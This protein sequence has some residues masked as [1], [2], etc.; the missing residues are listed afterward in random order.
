MELE[1]L[2]V[3]VLNIKF[4]TKISFRIGVPIVCCTKY[5]RLLNVSLVQKLLLELEF[6][7]VGVLNIKFS[8]KI[9]FRIGV[10]IVWCTKYKL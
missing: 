1:F 7:I 2:L 4:S 8:T 3:E 9:P 5:K 10:P 6:L